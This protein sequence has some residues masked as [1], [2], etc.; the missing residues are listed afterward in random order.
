MKF[1]VY[2]R[3]IDR[4]ASM[5]WCVKV[6]E[7]PIIQTAES[8]LLS[9]KSDGLLGSGGHYLTIIECFIASEEEIG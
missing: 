3:W 1:V 5:R 4:D 6:A 7:F 8:F 2:A 9:I